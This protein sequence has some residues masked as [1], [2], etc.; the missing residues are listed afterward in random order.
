MIFPKDKPLPERMDIPGFEGR[1]YVC[2]DGTVWHKWKSTDTQMFGH[3][4]GRGREMKLTDENGKIH[5][6]TMSWIMKHTYFAGMDPEM[7]L[8]HKNGI[9]RDWSV[10]NLKPITRHNLGKKTYRNHDARAVLKI[11]PETGEILEVYTSSREAGKKNHCSYQAILDACN[12]KNIKRKGIAPDGFLYRWE[13]RK[14]GKEKE[15]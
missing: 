4:K 1:Y 15:N 10:H 6:K 5:S 3:K 8:M 7:V 13:G 14:Y 12:M 2:M 9:E 11:H